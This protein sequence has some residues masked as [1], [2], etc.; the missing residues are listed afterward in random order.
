MRSELK[1]MI[2]ISVWSLIFINVSLKADN[3]YAA[4]IKIRMPNGIIIQKQVTSLKEGRYKNII[5]QEFD[6]SC[7]AASLATIMT[8]YYKD[9]IEEIE[10]V[11]YI[12]EKSDRKKI[13]K[14]GFSLLDLKA[15][16]VQRNYQ[17]AGYKNVKSDNLRKLKFPTIVLLSSKKYS[18]FVLLKGVRG[19]TAFLADPAFG[20]RTMNI[21]EFE[22]DWNGVILLVVS[23]TT[24]LKELALDTTILAPESDIMSI[25][26]IGARGFQSFGSF[27]TV[28]EF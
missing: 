3:G 27:Q 24:K 13:A 22:R 19:S 2:M 4:I 20:N 15:F 26:T 6:L 10:I 17:V 21:E 12:L 11:K 1:W 7:G 5:R 8:Y 16:A 28:G 18:H 23:N 25:Q 14:K 9:P